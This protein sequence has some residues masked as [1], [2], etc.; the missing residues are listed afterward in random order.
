MDPKA[1]TPAPE[2]QNNTPASAP[3][4]T[5]LSSPPDSGSG[6]NVKQSPEAG[7]TPDGA[8]GQA[9]KTPA[10]EADAGKA[11]AE[12]SSVPEKYEFKMPEGASPDIKLMEGFEPLAK[13]L[14]LS[15]EQAQKLVDLYAKH[16]TDLV[17]T[18]EKALAEERKGWRESFQKLPNTGEI[19][20]NAKRAL[21]SLANAD[22]KQL[23]T[24]SWLGDH[25]AIIDLLSKAGKLLAEHPMHTGGEPSVTRKSN[26]EVFYPSSQ[27]KG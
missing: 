13:E 10:P 15:N 2:A 6:N 11:P 1:T 16:T 14:K 25:P 4:T 3:E 20:S 26:A 18:Q 12:T 5:L 17:Q 24:N 8:A 23:L 21:D 19:L 7:T 27:K 22:A 9:P